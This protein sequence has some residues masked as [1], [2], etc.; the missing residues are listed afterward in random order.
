[1]N[2]F[3]ITAIVSNAVLTIEKKNREQTLLNSD[4][5]CQLPFK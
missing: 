4:V 3:F 1:M 5:D 2:N